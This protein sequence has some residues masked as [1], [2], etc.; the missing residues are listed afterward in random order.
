MAAV[1]VKLNTRAK[2]LATKALLVLLVGLLAAFT[3]GYTSDQGR[4]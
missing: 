3:L 1:M 2:S 4:K